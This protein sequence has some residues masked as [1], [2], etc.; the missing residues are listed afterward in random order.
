MGLAEAALRRVA[1]AVSVLD[2]VDLAIGDA[3]VTLPDPKPVLVPWRRV[4]QALG[5]AAPD[6][7]LARLRLAEWLL[8]ARWASGR[9][10]ASW[11]RML[12]RSGSRSTPRCTRDST[13][14]GN[15]SPVAPWTSGS[16]FSGP[17]PGFR[18]ASSRRPGGSS[19]SSA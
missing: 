13:G 8:A 14:S 4:R 15:A 6:S 11:P 10:A 5:T 16:A 17:I 18:T 9:A 3:G 19:T 12:D 2:D 1:L 7:D